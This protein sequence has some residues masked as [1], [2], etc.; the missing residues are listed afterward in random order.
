MT[1]P[2]RWVAVAVIARPHALGGA[3]VLKALTRSPDDLLQAGLK[4]LYPRR[5]DNVLQPLTVKKMALHKGAPLV[6]FEE[7]TDRTAAEQLVGCELVIPAEERWDL[8]EGEYYADDLA[9]L[10]VFEAAT[11][12]PLGDVIRVDEGAAHDY[13]VLSH[14]ADPRREVLL[15]YVPEFVLS[16]DLEAGRVE[17]RIPEGLLEL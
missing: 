5:R 11:G 17:V 1:A 4:R 10:A 2:D 16:I 15:P 8:D 13:L 7:V 9:G 6:T 14:P 12:A 3:L